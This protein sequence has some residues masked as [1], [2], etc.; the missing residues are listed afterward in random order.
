MVILLSE[1]QEIPLWLTGLSLWLTGLS[2]LTDRTFTLTDR[3][4]SLADR[5]FSLDWQDFLSD[6]QDFLSCWQDFLSDWQD[7]LSDWQDFLSDWQDFLSDWQD[8]LSDWQDFLSDWQD[9][10]SDWQDFWQQEQCRVT[11]A[12]TVSN[13]Q[14]EFQRVGTEFYEY[15]KIQPRKVKIYQKSRSWFT[16]NDNESSIVTLFPELAHGCLRNTPASWL[17]LNSITEHSGWGSVTCIK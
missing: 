16:S 4:F 13:S 15:V 5:I 3:T 12:T 7:F 2:L 1:F 6:W 11:A 8:F 9:F 10:L 14:Q 17:A